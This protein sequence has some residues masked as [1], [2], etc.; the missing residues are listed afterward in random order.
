ML[1]F[2]L[3][4]FAFAATLFFVASYPYFSEMRNGESF[5]ANLRKL[6]KGKRKGSNFLALTFWHFMLTFCLFVLIPNDG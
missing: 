3:S 1:L 6:Q 5:Y 4:Y 2:K